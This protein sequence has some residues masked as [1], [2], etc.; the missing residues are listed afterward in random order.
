M[1]IPVT[2][3]VGFVDGVAKDLYTL[4]LISEWILGWIEL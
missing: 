4:D 2:T 3:V 1:E